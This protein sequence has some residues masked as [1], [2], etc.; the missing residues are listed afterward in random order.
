MDSPGAGPLVR[1]DPPP[2]PAPGA[3]VAV[4]DSQEPISVDPRT[5][6]V[7]TLKDEP[8]D[9]LAE[10]ALAFKEEESRLAGLRKLV[11]DELTRRVGDRR[12]LITDEFELQVTPGWSRKWDAPELEG[13]LTEL[14]DEGVVSAPEVSAVLH[15]EL[16]VDGRAA[17]RLLKRLGG[18]AL[19]RVTRC[20]TWQP[21]GRPKLEITRAIPLIQNPSPEEDER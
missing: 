16:T 10:V 17:Q 1:P 15:R 8:T 7:L 9:L 13:T 6:E 4:R 3:S 2:E 21:K 14:H 19:D 20:F 12:K 11:E 5:G 18:D